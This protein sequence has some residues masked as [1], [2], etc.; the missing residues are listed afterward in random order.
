MIM[1]TGFRIRQMCCL[2]DHSEKFVIQS[3]AATG[4]GSRRRRNED[5]Y[6]ADPDG[7]VFIVAD[8]MGGTS[9]GERASQL[10]VDS[11]SQSMSVLADDGSAT[12]ADV[13]CAIRDAFAAANA[14]IIREARRDVRYCRM[15]TTAVVAL[16][17]GPRLYIASIG[18]SRAYLVRHHRIRQLTVDH[19]WSQALVD[20]GVISPADAL[21]HKMRNVLCKYL[22]T[23]ELGEGPDVQSVDL[24]DGDQILLSTDGITSVLDERLI[25]EIVDSS[26]RPAD[27]ATRLLQAARR[28]NATDDVTCVV[29]GVDASAP[30]ACTRPDDALERDLLTIGN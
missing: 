21:R 23:V 11:L 4:T 24:E 16:L 20:A 12:D 26:V 6:Y 7:R 28:N 5:H 27:A 2:L 29:L 3:A 22:G 14:D 17:V 13:M 30:E 9:G 1:N 10:A 18:D 15:G 8:G 19:T 25:L